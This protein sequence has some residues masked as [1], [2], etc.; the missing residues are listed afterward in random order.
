MGV[1]GGGGGKEGKKHKRS[2]K[3]R[4]CVTQR[5]AYYSIT[6]PESMCL[7][8]QDRQPHPTKSECRRIE[9]FAAGFPRSA[10]DKTNV[11][12]LGRLQL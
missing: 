9:E 12:L 4:P 1:D 6:Q 2:T 5:P 3:T 10:A 11:N 8:Q 7:I